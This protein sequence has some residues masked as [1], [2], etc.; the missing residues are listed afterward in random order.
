MFVHNP[1]YPHRHG[2]HTLLSVISL[3]TGR[4]PVLQCRRSVEVIYQ[5]STERG[6]EEPQGHGAD[7]AVSQEEGIP[8]AVHNPRY[9]LVF[10]FP[11]GQAAQ[12]EGPA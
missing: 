4:L 8:A 6:D 1:V 10:S 12:H 2:I 11:H 7:R 5:H 9:V 3:A